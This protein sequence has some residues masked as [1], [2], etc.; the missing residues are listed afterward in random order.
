[1]PLPFLPG[2]DTSAVPAADDLVVAATVDGRVAALPDGSLPSIAALPQI[3]V[4][5]IGS[6]D[7]R[8][9]WAGELTAV[10]DKAEMRSWL[11]L[12]AR[13]APPVAAVVARG[14]Y[15]VRWRHTNR[16]C[17]E[18]GGELRDSPGFTT[19]HCPQCTTLRYVPNALSPVVIVAVEHDERLL[20]VRQSYGPHQ[21]NWDLVAGFVEAG[22]TLEGAA[23]R[24][25]WEETGL[26]PENLAYIG[27]HPWSFSGPSVLLTSFTATV[28]DPVL[29]LDPGEIAQ[30]RWFSRAELRELAPAEWPTFGYT[31]SLIER[32][33]AD[34]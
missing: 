6:L 26:V 4:R 14:F 9:I 2:Y 28:T 31:I 1:M 17:G 16:H 11:E 18:C 25:L 3:A 21:E 8:P 12:T 30:A 24:E 22:E 19:R 10:P 33:L 13:L 32:F 27:S 29:R 15:Q 5:H 20:L 23:I 34:S 7:G